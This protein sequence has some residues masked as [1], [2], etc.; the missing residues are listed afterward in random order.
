V[1]IFHSVRRKRHIQI[2]FRRIVYSE[3]IDTKIKEASSILI[4]LYCRKNSPEI[5]GILMW[6]SWCKTFEFFHEIIIIFAGTTIPT[7]LV[8]V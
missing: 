4:C 1:N 7:K 8:G 3:W 2:K 6:I 5:I